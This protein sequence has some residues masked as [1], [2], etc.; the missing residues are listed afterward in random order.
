MSYNPFTV[1]YSSPY[2]NQF[3]MWL[4]QNNINPMFLN[5]QQKWN[6]F[7]TFLNQFGL[8]SMMQPQNISPNPTPIPNPYELSGGKVKERLPRNNAVNVINT[9]GQNI[10]NVTLNASTGNKTVI[11]ASADTTIE[12]LL[13]MYTTKIGLSKDVIGKEIMFLYNGAQLDCKSKNTIGSIFRNTA[14]ITVY[15]LGG[16]IGA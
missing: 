12:N 10:I 15:D 7:S 5:E 14:V 6:Y 4:Q 11:N 3:L 8:G 2:W 13:L 9:G 1:M 16:I